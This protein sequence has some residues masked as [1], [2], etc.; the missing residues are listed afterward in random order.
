[1]IASIAPSTHGLPLADEP[2]LGA[3]TLA[4]FIREVTERFT[5]REALAFQS[6]SGEVLR[7]SYGDLYERSVEVA[8]A[9]IAA[10]VFKGTRVGVLMT[11]RPEW[12]ASVFG[13]SLAGGVAVTLNTFATPRELEY[14][15]RE[16]DISVLIIERSVL[17]R[18]FLSDLIEICP[19]ITEHETGRLHLSQFPFLRRIVCFGDEP[20]S[21][22]VDS[23]KNFLAGATEVPAEF[24][25]SV[26]AEISPDDA[27]VIFFSSGST[28]LPKGIIHAHRAAG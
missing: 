19:Q 24:I 10:G 12:V 27:A 23:W 3:M 22:A 14:L 2:G 6:E 15:I 4:G 21:H 28:A 1:M 16:S 13:I 9:L 26:A 20:A 8:K 11:N 18:D 7:W 17:K 25:D 5:D